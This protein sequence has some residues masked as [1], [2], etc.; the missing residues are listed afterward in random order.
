MPAF[1]TK[2]ENGIATVTLDRVDQPVNTLNADMVAEWEEL[3]ERLRA[4]S[5]VRGVVLISGKPDSFIA[6]ADIDQFS[7]FASPADAEALSGR[8]QEMMQR[9]EDFPKP[10]VAAIHGACVGGGYELA[11]ACHWRVATDS[12][13]TQLGLPE[14]Q[15]GVIPALGGCVRLPRLIGPRAALDIILAGKTERASKALKLGMVDEVVPQSILRPV[16]A[17]AADRLSRDGKPNR[18]RFPGAAAALV[19]GTSIGRQLIYRAARKQ[20]LKKSGGNYPAPLTALEVV[21]IGLERGPAE[22]FRAERERFGEL[23]LGPVSRRLVQIFFATNALKKDDGVPAGTE[24]SPLR[25]RR[26]GIVGSGFMGAAIAGTAVLNAEV[27][28]RLKDSELPRVGKGLKAALGILDERLKRRRL[29]RPQHERLAGLLSGTA[30]YSGFTRLDLVIEAVFEDLA[31]KRRVLAEVEAEI[32]PEAIFA[33]NTSTIP[34][35]DIAAGARRPGRVVGMHFFSPVERMPLLEVIPAERTDPS[36]I[37]SAVRFGRAMGKTVIVVRDHPGFWVNRIL[38]PYLNEAGV[39]VEEG[40]PIELIDSAMTRWGFPVGP[41]TLLDEVGLDVAQKA[42]SVMHGAFGERLTP[43]SVV[44]RMLDDNRLGRKNARGFYVYHEGHK[45]GVDE[46]VYRVLGVKP[47]EGS[48]LEAVQQR[49]VY[50]MLNEAALAYAEGVVRSARDGDIG[51]IFGIG[52]PPFRG[53]PLRFIDD[54]G[55][56]QVVDTLRRLQTEHGARFAP[57]PVLLEMAR[58]GERFH[59]E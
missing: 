44:G 43:S 49:L 12:S 57:A 23:A 1:S 19:D 54:V 10:I 2:A 5:G 37:A 4:D 14:V 18:N 34:I 6:G 53:G 42:A 38:S 11:L 17:A 26:L 32:P 22:G 20:V 56:G 40:A 35:R 55:V 45:T 21:K 3:L 29:T 15:L 28:A 9:V 7:Q 52:F 30:D 16:A 46:R 58:K 41:V 39:L 51:A 8:G 36:T 13:K 27:E 24:V 59:P 48:K 31:V 50:L 33:S 47:R 25:V